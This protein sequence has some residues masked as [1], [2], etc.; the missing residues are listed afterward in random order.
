MTNSMHG[1]VDEALLASTEAGWRMLL[2]KGLKAF[3]E[4]GRRAT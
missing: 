3:V 4:T 2:E 1:V